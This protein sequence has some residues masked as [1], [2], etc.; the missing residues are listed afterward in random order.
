MRSGQEFMHWLELGAGSVWIRR[1]AIVFGTL[2]LSMLV[3][4]KQF[5]GPT[6]EATLIQAD[7]GRQLAN[8]RG[9]STHVI[10]PQTQAVLHAR[11]V[12][13]DPARS[14]P[15]LNQAPLYSIVIGG[16]LRLLPEQRRL[17]L[18]ATAPTP[19]DGFAADYFLLGL[20]LVL[21]W[22]A[23]WLTYDLGKRLFEPRAGL[24][25]SFGLLVSVAIWQETV[26]VNGTPLLMVLTLFAFHA[27]Q[28]VEAGAEMVR[29]ERAP[30]GWLVG[31]GVASALMFL[32]EYSAGAIV[33]V[34][35]AYGALRFVGRARLI[36]VGAVVLGFA[37]ASGPWVA[38]NVTITGH[39]VG[40]A[41]QNVALKAGDPTAE[42]ATVRGTL[43]ATAPRLDLK[44]LANKTLTT[45]QENL[46]SRLWAGGAMW[47]SAFFVAGWLYAFRTS[48]SNRLRWVAT[49]VLG[50][51][52]LTQA[53][54]NSGET[55]RH[56]AVWFSPV[57]MIFGAGFFFVLLGSNAA[58]SQWPRAA[59]TALVIVQALPLVHDALEPRRLHFQYPPYFPGLFMGLRQELERRGTGGKFGIMADVPAGVAWYG[60]ARAWQQPPTLRDFYAITLEQPI[61][62]LLLTP[63]TLDRPFF[64]EL[65]ARIVL[66]GTLG[67]LPN[68]FGE[69][70]EVYAGLLT[71]AMP[72]DFPLGA[73]QK[74]AENLYVLL[75]PSLPPPRGK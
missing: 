24:V 3:A 73:P 58:L 47:F 1:A 49:A 46:K 40:L 33:L 8:G 18:F 42:P 13:F 44:K 48:A 2:A 36:A 72:R 67:V 5:H 54:L 26:A 74:L 4:W 17:A 7:V 14:N 12:R 56:V 31:L 38:R 71:G 22:L 29:G 55:E 41:A 63:R 15:E 43:S 64:S 53:A 68:R 52:L 69:W 57:L 11:G 65:N 34:A 32:T 66:P 9:F 35:I 60:Q 30:F 61:G 16:A 25:A 75:N 21:L 62:E 28:R 39:P 10:Y 50:G 23:A 20:N 70:G 27:W 51:L 45:L 59:A 37:L 19:P 6:S